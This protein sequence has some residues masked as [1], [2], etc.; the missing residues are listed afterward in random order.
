[1][2]RLRISA[3]AFLGGEL[4][5]TGKMSNIDGDAHSKFNAEVRGIQLADMN[6]ALK[7]SALPK[8]VSVAGV[9]NAQATAAWGK[10]FEDVVAHADAAVQG[11]VSGNA[12]IVPVESAIHG[13]YTGR[14]QELALKQSFAADAAKYADDEWGG[15]PAVE[16]GCEISVQQFE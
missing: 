14:N 11:K 16:P 7:S 6:R 10:T 3:R 15:E 4:T 8:G 9:L 2:P 5:S 1:M 12:Q 13:T